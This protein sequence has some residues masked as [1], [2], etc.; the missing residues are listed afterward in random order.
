VDDE[1][2]KGESIT[3]AMAT[4]SV[5]PK[6]DGSDSIA[7]AAIRHRRSFAAAWGSPSGLRPIGLGYLD[8]VSLSGRASG[9][10]EYKPTDYF[11]F[12]A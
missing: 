2:R 9:A 10:R 4:R 3:D 6:T 11:H 8:F 5:K 12:L 7:L 1:N